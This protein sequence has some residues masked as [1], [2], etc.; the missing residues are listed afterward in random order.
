MLISWILCGFIVCIMFASMFMYLTRKEDIRGRF[1]LDHFYILVI[2]YF[3]VM[4]GYGL[5]Y[6]LLA[7]NGI[8]ITNEGFLNGD[9]PLENLG[10]AIYFSGVTLMTVGYGDITPVGIGK[11]IALTEAMLG[12]LLPSAFFIRVLFETNRSR[13]K[14]YD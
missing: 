13:Q 8:Q 3:N 11:Y 12:Y 10:H 14:Y 6:F 4:I 7:H 1:S 2:I 5:I 9:S